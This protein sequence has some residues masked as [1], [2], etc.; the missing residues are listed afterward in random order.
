MT[1]K[2]IA[3]P[4]KL[5]EKLKAKKKQHE[6]FPELIQRLLDKDD[7]KEKIP[8]KEYFGTL[9]EKEEDE[10]EKIEMTLYEGRIRR[11][12]RPSIKSEE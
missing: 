3:I 1:Q 9:V 7:S 12:T 4:E 2:T 6:T 11:N 10:W 8:I 5:Y